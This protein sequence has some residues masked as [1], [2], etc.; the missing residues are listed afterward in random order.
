MTEKGK[1]RSEPDLYKGLGIIATVT[2]AT[3][4]LP[5]EVQQRASA[6]AFVIFMTAAGAVHYQRGYDKKEKQVLKEDFRSAL[7]PYFW[8]SLFYLVI[9]SLGMFIQPDRFTLTGLYEHIWNS[10]TF[11]GISV[12]WFFP[13]Y[14]LAVTAYRIF[15]NVFSFP[16]MFV[17]LSV[18]CMVL[19]FIL[20]RRGYNGMIEYNTAAAGAENYMLRLALLFWRSATG[21]FFCMWGEALARMAAFLK[22]R[23]AACVIAA[24]AAL[25]A[26]IVLSIFAPDTDLVSM[27]MDNPFLSIPAIMLISGGL[28][29]LCNWI[30]TVRPVD[31]LGRNAIIIYLSFEDLR[32][33]KLARYLGDIVFRGL[34]NNFAMR[35]TVALVILALE[36]PLIL[37]LSRRIFRPFFGGRDFS[38]PGPEEDCA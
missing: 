16:W 31:F 13:V 37:I 38:A 11:M 27:R 28:F 8:F 9:D 5:V 32:I 30:R 12:L 26:G 22:T 10:V 20:Y 33:L 25:A 17:V 19:L 14:F 4:L 24:F 18:L 36:I 34:D 6:L 3:H 7:V 35:L 1:R 15:R 29:I 23:K 2:A 21:L